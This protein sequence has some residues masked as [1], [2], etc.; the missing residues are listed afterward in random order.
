MSVI[1]GSARVDEKG[2]YQGGRPG[3]Q[4]QKSTVQDENGEVSMQPF[5]LHKK[6]WYIL[7]PANKSMAQ[8]MAK[9]M[10]VAAN[11]PNIGYSQSDRAG[12][13]KCGVNSK[14]PTNCDCSSLVRQ[15][16][17]ESCGRDVGNFTTY[18]EA[19]ILEKSGL[20]EKRIKY[21]N[22]KETPLRTGDVLVTCSKGHTVVVVKGIDSKEE[23]KQ[24]AKKPVNT[25]AQYYPK[26]TIS[27]NSIVLALKSVG[28]KDYSFAHRRLIA[29][30]NGISASVYEGSA[31][32][33]LKLLTLIKKGELKKA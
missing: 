32:Q 25:S 5:Y 17:R 11:N 3:D 19:S 9:C 24:P 18:N 20:F 33:N 7:R 2:E 8:N 22:S 13:L 21:I 14:I 23:P 1:L 28:E 26:C 29:A 10:I 15:C 27:T 6:G 30:A 4:K 31:Q 16:I 12:I